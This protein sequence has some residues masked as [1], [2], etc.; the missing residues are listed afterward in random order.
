MKILLITFF[1]GSL[2]VMIPL[3]RR[4]LPAPYVTVTVLIVGLNPFFWQFKDQVLSDVPFLFFLLVSLL[5]FMRADEGD[6]PARHR[7]MLAV[8]S[9]VAAYAAYATRTLGLMLIPCYIAHDL[10]RYRRLTINAALPAGIALALASLQYVFW[11][12]D[13]SYFDSLASPLAVVRNVTAYL[14][15]LADL[16][17]N[18]YS[19]D[20]RR[21]LFLGAGVVAAVGYVSSWRARVSVLHL[22]PP[23][24]LAPVLA[25]PRI[26]G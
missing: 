12:H 1:V 19:N 22:F 8:L 17:E 23:L 25:W 6:D 16:W 4:V 7:T 26:K 24:Y 9:G 18:G 14:R 20:V 11:V 13:D 5:L 21:I 3:F 2:L 15:T 10:I